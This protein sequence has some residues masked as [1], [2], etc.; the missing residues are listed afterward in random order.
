MNVESRLITVLNYS[1]NFSYPLKNLN[2]SNFFNDFL[3]LT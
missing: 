2:G 3:I 1:L